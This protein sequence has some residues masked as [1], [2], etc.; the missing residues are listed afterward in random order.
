VNSDGG[1]GSVRRLCK[2][3]GGL[4]FR[5]CTLTVL[6]LDALRIESSSELRSYEGSR[7]SFEAQNANELRWIAPCQFCR[8]CDSGEAAHETHKDTDNFLSR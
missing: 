2:L 8:E 6:I 7:P 4:K 3:G 1:S 5:K